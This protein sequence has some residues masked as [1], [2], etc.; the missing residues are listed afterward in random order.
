MTRNGHA[1]LYDEM[2]E[3]ACHY[4][5]LIGGIRGWVDLAQG[6]PTL[7]GVRVSAERALTEIGRLVDQ[8]DTD[9]ATTGGDRP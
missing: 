7:P 5:R 4:A 1:H 8:F 6:D 9:P 3:K 2:F